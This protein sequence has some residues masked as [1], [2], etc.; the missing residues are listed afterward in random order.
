MHACICD[1][2]ICMYICLHMCMY[3][4]RHVYVHVCMNVF[5]WCMCVYGGMT[6]YVC[7][8]GCVYVSMYVG[9]SISIYVL[10][11]LAICALCLQQSPGVWW[12]PH[13][14]CG[15]VPR[16][17][18]DMPPHRTRKIDP[19]HLLY[20]FPKYTHIYIATHLCIST[21]ISRHLYITRWSD[22][23]AFVHLPSAAVSHTS[24]FFL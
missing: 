9:M 1:M 21:Y 4:C 7:I 10:V 6:V 12:E 20:V 2:Y 5:P 3:G 14:N 23:Q 24:I 22:R 15:W 16:R 8:Y 11:C 18:L 17:L 13:G 19:D